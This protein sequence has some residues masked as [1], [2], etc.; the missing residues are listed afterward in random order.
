MFQCPRGL[1]DFSH[2]PQWPTADQLN[3]ARFNAREGLVTFPTLAVAACSGTYHVTDVPGFNAREGLVTFPTTQP[4]QVPGWFRA[5]LFQCPRGLGDF[6]H[7]SFWLC[8]RPWWPAARVSMPA[9][10]W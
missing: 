8:W 5:F 4:A 10:A 7:L 2:G 9:R 1:G 6:S 3:A